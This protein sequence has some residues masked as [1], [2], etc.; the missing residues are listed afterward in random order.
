M[1]MTVMNFTQM[2]D[3]EAQ[4]ILN[5]TK[6]PLPDW[7]DQTPDTLWHQRSTQD[8]TPVILLEGEYTPDELLAMLHVYLTTPGA[9]RQVLLARAVTEAEARMPAGT[10]GNL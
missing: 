10:F 6:D 9:T 5:T 8:S 3:V 1:I 7:N 4:V 2:T